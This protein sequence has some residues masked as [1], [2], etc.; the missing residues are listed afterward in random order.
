MNEEQLM[1][2]QREVLNSIKI[3]KWISI[4]LFCVSMILIVLFV[5]I[6]RMYPEL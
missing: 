4:I 1:N 2:M 5:Q 6:S 3:L